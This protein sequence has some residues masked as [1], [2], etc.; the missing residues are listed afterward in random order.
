MAGIMFISLFVL[1][2]LGVP[3]A[4]SLASAG[5]ISVLYGG[6]IPMIIVPQRLFVAMDSFP[7]MAVPLF[8]LAGNLMEFGGVSTRLVGFARSLVGHIRGGLAF[9]NV[10]VS[11]LFA[12]ISGSAV[13]DT[14]AVGSTMLPAMKRE[15]YDMRFSSSLQASAGAIGIIIPPSVPMIIYAASASGVS[16]GA[17]FLAG[18][19]PGIMIG[20]VL[21][22]LS[23]VFS[24]NVKG[25]GD[26]F[27]WSNVL[28][29]GK[30]A[31]FAMAM[32]AIILG[33]IM[34]GVFTPTESAVIAVF[35][36][37]V[38]GG[39]VYRD[40]SLHHFPEIVKRTALGTGSVMFIIGAASIY[41][42]VLTSERIPQVITGFL[43]S[44]SEERWVIILLINLILLI[45]GTFLETIAAIIIMV[46]ILFPIAVSLG[47][48]PVHFGI[49]LMVNLAIGMITPPVGITLI[50]ACSISKV[51]IM[52]TMK[53]TMSIVGGMLLVLGVVNFLPDLV[54]LLPN[55]M[56]H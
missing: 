2:I 10:L 22:I 30:D 27:L 40:L 12:G 35:Y 41:G 47:V 56:K 42:W 55:L 19:L 6:S 39:F 54:M 33:G 53:Y 11:M 36:A 9:V 16:I 43:L 37:L 14:A 24:G 7:L 15:G 4:F 52:D 44:V 26:S 25:E 18:F 23:Y 29:K 3:I 20:L 21:I 46:P 34:S 49:I 17:L 45:V 31:V 50:V 8:F 13:A 5:L 32:P 38:V 48:D 28:H 51:S 1:L